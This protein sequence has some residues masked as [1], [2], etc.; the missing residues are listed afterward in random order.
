MACLPCLSPNHGLLLPLPLYF[1]AC[2]SC[3]PLRSHLHLW[4]PAS[5]SAVPVLKFGFLFL[6]PAFR[7]LPPTTPQLPLAA[8][9]GGWGKIGVTSDICASDLFH[10]THSGS[11]C[12]RLGPRAYYLR[13]V[14]WE[15]G[16]PEGN[17]A[18]SLLEPPGVHGGVEHIPREQATREF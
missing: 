10:P 8:G 7:L 3:C 6:F 4:G 17:L 1:S 9:G 12:L 13:L 5:V 2:L 11:V 15:C 18:W 16:G 14:L